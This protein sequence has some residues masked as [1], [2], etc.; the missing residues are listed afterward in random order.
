MRWERAKKEAGRK[1]GF[2]LIGNNRSCQREPLFLSS[3]F[4][5]PVQQGLLLAQ[6]PADF[7][8]GGVVGLFVVGV[9][10]FFVSAGLFVCM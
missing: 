6:E 3:F 9:T 8:M 2:F 7:P 5:E 10:G 1:P 4:P